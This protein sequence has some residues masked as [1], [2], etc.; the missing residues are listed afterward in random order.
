MF[1][2]DTVKYFV[3]ELGFRYIDTGIDTTNFWNSNE[4]QYIKLIFQDVFDFYYQNFRGKKE[5]IWSLLEQTYDYYKNEYRL[6]ACGAGIISYYL[7][8]I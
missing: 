7:C 2:L 3:D 6:Y 8:T 5:F 4:R 1:Y